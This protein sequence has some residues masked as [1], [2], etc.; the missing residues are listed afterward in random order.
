[1]TARSHTVPIPCRPILEAIMR[2]GVQKIQVLAALLSLLALL[3]TGATTTISG[4]QHSQENS[5]RA[6]ARFDLSKPDGGP[7]PSDLFTVADV[8]QNTG[9][10]VNLPY[11]DCSIRV[12]D[13]EDLNVINTLDG[14]GLQ[15]R[16]SIPFDSPI[17]PTSVN[18]ENVFLIALE[19]YFPA[20]NAGGNK[21]GVNQVVWDPE[22]NTLHVETDDLLDQARRYAVI[23]T[24]GVL[25]SNG[26][27]VKAS[28]QFR[29]LRTDV[30]SWYRKLLLQAIATSWRPACIPLKR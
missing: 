15:T 27:K 17:D 6:V 23:V 10:R 20:A 9:R 4:S 16:V 8:N 12:S 24:E 5:P 1:M 29:H 14:F 30:P 19:S 11:P 2:T 3:L 26:V 21:V 7:F 13:C 18:S 22:T 25:G 28:K